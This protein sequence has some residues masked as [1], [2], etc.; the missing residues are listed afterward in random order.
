MIDKNVY[1]IQK[2]SK[3]KNS[4]FKEVI[5]HFSTFNIRSLVW[6]YYMQYSDDILH[7]YYKNSY[8]N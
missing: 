8:I 4:L 6:Y 2:L 7:Y 1:L 3:N 5:R